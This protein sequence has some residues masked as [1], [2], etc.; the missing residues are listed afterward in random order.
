MQTEREL[1]LHKE[2]ELMEEAKD[3]YIRT[4]HQIDQLEDDA[5][6]QNRRGKELNDELFESYSQDK[7]LQQILTRGEELLQ[8]Q[9]LAEN[10]F[11]RECREN[12]Q[13]MKKEAELQMDDY[14]EEIQKIQKGTT[15]EGEC[16]ED[17]NYDDFAAAR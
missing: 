1:Q 9:I 16:N 5:L 14:R 17:N 3:Q 12:L 15:N 4:E 8:Q 11:F 10:S 2:L 7:K 6:W 13:E